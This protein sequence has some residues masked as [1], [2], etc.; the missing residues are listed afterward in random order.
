MRNASIHVAATVAANSSTSKRA[1]TRL[2]TLVSPRANN[3]QYCHQKSNYINVRVLAVCERRKHHI[4]INLITLEFL[5]NFRQYQNFIK[6]ILICL[7]M[8]F[9]KWSILRLRYIRMIGRLSSAIFEYS[10]IYF[11]FSSM[12]KK[13]YFCSR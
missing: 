1:L 3:L 7:S 2:A 9:V 8:V 6:K 5:I 12:N 13:I 4:E 11:N 10:V